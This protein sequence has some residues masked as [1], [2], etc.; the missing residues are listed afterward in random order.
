MV[1]HILSSLMAQTVKHLPATWEN[2]VWLLGRED[3]LEKETATHSSTPTWKIPWMEE[4][5]RLQSM[6]SQRVGHDRVTSLSLFSA[7]MRD[8]LTLTSMTIIKKSPNNKCWRRSREKGTLLHS[9]WECRLVQPLR[10]AVQRFLT[11]L[12]IELPYDA[13]IPWLGMYPEKNNNSKRHTYPNVHCSTVH[14]R[15]DKEAT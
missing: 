5:G 12:D 4:P 7:H 9:W 3:P 1:V 10:T 11:K 6:G 8:H 13:A 14:N 15:Q 2:Q